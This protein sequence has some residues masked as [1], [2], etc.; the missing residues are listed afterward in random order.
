MGLKDK[1]MPQRFVFDSSIL[2]SVVGGLS[3]IDIPALNIHTLDAADSFLLSY[4]FDLS[5]TKDLEKLHHYHR[6][7]M[8]LMIE[9]LGI[10]EADIPEIFR[11]LK[12]L[13]DIRNL[14]IFASDRE[15]D[16]QDLQRWACAVIR[17]MHVFVHAEN[18]LFNDVEWSNWKV[19]IGGSIMSACLP[20]QHKLVNMFSENCLDEKLIRYFNEYYAYSDID[21]M[22]GQEDI[23]IKEGRGNKSYKDGSLFE[24]E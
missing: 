2:S 3:V 10:A 7:A 23:F 17:C 14:L 18:D 24:G 16:R 11:D 21:V 1:S 13:G 12:N 5:Q 4:G 22:F 8:V 19:A 20:K 15:P 6:R 9:K